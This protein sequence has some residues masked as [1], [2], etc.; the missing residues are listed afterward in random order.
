MFFSGDD[1]KHGGELWK[2]DGTAAGTIL[3]KQTQPFNFNT[4]LSDFVNLNGTLLFTTS[5]SNG[6]TFND[7][8]RSDGTQAGTTLVTPMFPI[9]GLTR[10]GSKVYFSGP[11][12][13]WVF[14]KDGKHLGTIKP[15]E[16]PANCNWGD[17]GKSLYMTARTG[18]YR[19][20]LAATGERTLYQ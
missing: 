10:F 11:G 6:T 15:P 7:L 2:T 1:G 5:N 17:D 14:S 20:K 16:I 9:L 13:I 4:E 8:W 3:V 18:L 19:I 12:G